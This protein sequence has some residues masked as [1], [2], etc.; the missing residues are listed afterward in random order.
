[1]SVCEVLFS[2]SQ[3][4]HSHQWETS[5]SLKKVRRKFWVMQYSRRQFT[6]TIHEEIYFKNY[7]S[8]LPLSAIAPAQ[9]GRF[10]ECFVSTPYLLAGGNLEASDRGS[11]HNP[12]SSA[13][14]CRS[15]TPRPRS[16]V[17]LNV[18]YLLA[19]VLRGRSTQ[20]LNKTK[21]SSRVPQRSEQ[22]RHQQEA[23]AVCA[24]FFADC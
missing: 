1:M 8:L 3:T 19:D 13:F 17:C 4:I 5:L 15:S 20:D 23:R 16:F 24:V 11:W 10:V 22:D 6:G 21:R 18:Y 12:S 7:K 14:S 9:L 2:N